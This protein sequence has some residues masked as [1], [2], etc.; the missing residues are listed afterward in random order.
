MPDRLS[1]LDASFLF[2]EEP[3]TPMHVGAVAV[4]RR[5]RSG[6]EYENLVEHVEQRLALVPRYRQKVVKVPAHLARPVWVDDAEFDINYH[7]RRSALPSP[8]SR[9]QLNELVARLMS[10]PLDHDRPLWEIYLVEGL[11][12]NRIALVTKTHNAVV[13][14]IDAIEIGQA[15]LDSAPDAGDDTASLWMPEPKPN[16]TQLVVDAVSEAMARP[17]EL[18]QNVRSFAGD[19]TATAQRFLDT[20]R[21]LTTAVRSPLRPAAGGP[22]AVGAT[23]SR[24]FAVATTKLEHYRAIRAAHGVSVNDVV[25]TA[26]TSALRGWLL[27]RGEQVGPS[28]VIRALAPLSVRDENG[29]NG[30]RVSEYLVDLPVGEPN[31][32]VRLHQVSH[33]MSAHVESGRSVAAKVLSGARRLT[34]TTLHALGARLAASLSGRLFSIVV[35]NVPGPQVPLYVAGAKMTEIAPV[36]PL[37]RSQA[38]SIGVTSYD[39]NVYFGLNAE[40]EGMPDVDILARLIEES[41]EEMRTSVVGVE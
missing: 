38:V 40:W 16:S 17:A 26:V 13:D 25:L 31:V 30:T 33:A 4:L 27:S 12:R 32:V 18:V 41:V 20:A 37:G 34:P 15:I 10:R 6:F 24:R 9:A 22:L 39:G 35:S 2:V 19:V 14:G 21:E 3:S 36:V 7:V 8:G 29:E 11:E 23:G 5:P 28:M 1:A